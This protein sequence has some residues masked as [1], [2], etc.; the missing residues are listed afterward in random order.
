MSSSDDDLPPLEDMSHEFEKAK[1]AKETAKPL[2][3]TT[4][5]H[6][7]GE[8][9]RPIVTITEPS[10]PSPEK[11]KSTA[12]SKKSTQPGGF[13]GF[14]KGFLSAKPAKK[15]KAAPKPQKEPEIVELKAN[16]NK[17]DE[18]LVIDE[19]QEKMKNLISKNEKEWCTDDLLNKVHGDETMMKQLDDPEVAKALEWMQ[20]D[21][22]G[23]AEYYKK[24]NP[25]IMEMF[26]S[27][28]GVIG[29]HMSTL[30]KQGD[31][32]KE[33]MNKPRVKELVLYLRTNPDR[34]NHMIRENTDPEFQE[35]IRFLLA[36]GLIKI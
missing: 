22:R 15:K 25:A 34:A 26:K 35:D 20:R 36:K 14:S 6:I 21:P 8:D 16:K 5:G 29:G 3:R 27:F 17:Q 4:G 2:T 1:S 30:D 18:S 13:G 12:Q 10:K 11:P 31:R 7:S 9:S 19:V 32:K 33:I 23:A 28:M 24:H